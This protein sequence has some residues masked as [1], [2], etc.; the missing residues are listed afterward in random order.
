MA[1]IVLEVRLVERQDHGHHLMNLHIILS[2][3]QASYSLLPSLLDLV[4]IALKERKD[5]LFLRGKKILNPT[6]Q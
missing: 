5:L 2:T 3:S 1:G 4:L 6:M